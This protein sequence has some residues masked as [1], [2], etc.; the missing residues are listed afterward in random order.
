MAELPD[1]V[2]L[3]LAL[4]FVIALMGGLAFILK[5]TGLG[6]AKAENT[7]DNKKRL[8]LIEVLPLDTR[9][10]LVIVQ[11]DKKQHLVLLG[12]NADTVIETNIQ[13]NALKDA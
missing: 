2:R 7:K 5:K 11:C 3:L 1:I 12:A 6:G 10:R 9:R 4:T 13:T 8:K